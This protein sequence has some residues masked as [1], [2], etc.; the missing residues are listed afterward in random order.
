VGDSEDIQKRIDAALRHL[1][2]MPSDPGGPVYT[3]QDETVG[4][5]VIGTIDEIS[6]LS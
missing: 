5:K 4:E 3:I 2:D 6:A 1:T